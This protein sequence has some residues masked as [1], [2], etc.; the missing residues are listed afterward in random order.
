MPSRF[1]VHLAQAD[2]GEMIMRVGQVR[3]RPS[4]HADRR[5]ACFVPRNLFARRIRADEHDAVAL[6]GNRFGA[7]LLR[8]DGVDVAVN[9]DQ[10]GRRDLWISRSVN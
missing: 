8:I 10:I 3:A 7:R 1:R 9:Q 2:A 6:D 5:R 4:R